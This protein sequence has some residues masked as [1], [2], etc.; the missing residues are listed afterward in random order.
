MTRIDDIDQIDAALVAAYRD[1]DI[2]ASASPK[3]RKAREKRAALAPD[4]GRRKRATGRTAQFNVKVKPE[5][6]HRTIQASRQ[7]DMPISVLVEKALEAYLAKL[8]K[9]E[10]PHA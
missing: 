3:A 2:K 9:K 7:H 1:T 6:R 4:D 8:M 5:L 10:Q